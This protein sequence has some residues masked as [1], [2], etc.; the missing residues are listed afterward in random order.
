M[1]RR[2]FLQGAAAGAAT[3][4]LG[5]WKLQPRDAAA[6]TASQAAAPPEYSGWGDV[7]RARWSWDRVGRST[8]FVNCWPQA[9]CTWNVYLKDGIAWREE[10]A[11]DY[12]QTRPDVP[13]FNPRGCQKGACYSERMYDPSRLQHPLK[14]AG[15]RGSGRW[16]RI[17]WEQ[18]LEEIADSL[19]ET[20]T[21]EAS[22]RVVF[23]LGPLYTLGV[24]SAAQQGLA[25][26]LDSVSLDPNTEIGDGMRGLGETFGKICFDRSGDDFFFSDL[27]LIWGGNPVATQIPNVHFL[28][29]ARYKGA[30]VVFIGPDYSPSAIHADLW[31]PVKPGC[32]A[33]LALGIAQVLVSKNL[34]DRDFVCEQTDLP[35]LVREDT[36]LYLRGSDLEEGGSDEQLYLHDPE[37]GVVA[38]PR[39]SLD[40]G[41]LRPSLD[42]RF[43]VTLAD[44]T[45]TTV[46]AVFA[47]LREQLA[48][49]TPEKASKLCGT[50]P[51]LIRDLARRLARAR[52]ASSLCTTLFAKY[53][54]GNLVMRAQALVFSLTG[55][56][57]KKGSGLAGVSFLVQDGL[58]RFAL[59]GLPLGRQV[60]LIAGVVADTAR[61]WLQGYTDE[62]RVFERYR[63]LYE[64][65]EL[66]SGAL[67]WYVHGG[68]VQASDRLQDWD[69]YLGRPVREV[70]EESL[71]KGWQHVWPKPGNDPRV[72][73]AV[74]S[75][76]LRRVRSYPRLLENLWPKLRTIVTLDWRM[77]STALHSDYVL[78]ITGWYERAEI[79]W[80]TALTPFVHAGAK[81]AEPHQESK[82]D[83]EVFSLLAK[84]IQQ[85]ARARGVTTFLDR[86]GEERRLDDVYENF[87][88]GGE[89]GPGDEEKVAEALLENASNLEGVTWKQLKERGWARFTSLGNSPVAIGSATEVAPD[90]TI[91]HFTQHV[92]EK[93]PWPT[94][95]RRIQFFLD[96]ELYLEMGEELPRHKDP[97]TAGGDY[98]LVLS[99]GHTRWSIHASWRDDALMLQQ[100]RG[101]PVIYVGALDAEARGIRD[102]EMVR[103]FNDLGEFQV[104]AKVSPGIRPGMLVIYHA[105]ENYQFQGGVGYQSLIPSPLNPVELSGGQHHLRPMAPCMQ[106]SHTDRDTRVEVA[107]L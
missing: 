54:H 1:R 74:G 89:F 99:G 32:D 65:G 68:V 103:V 44:G 17:G 82:S 37:R 38:A 98:P 64:S 107:R 75:N 49:Y 66:M 5:L 27:I 100:Q 95:S 45:P 57:G 30:Q 85:Q 7:Y 84:S 88:R 14:R 62:M 16:Q 15:E 39:R 71:S 81:V 56:F 46:R 41:E 102:G 79:K 25:L 53:Y 83:W 61:L 26:L 90:D 11:G 23:D 2:E 73:F 63:R 67:F 10:Q 92:F 105:W 36:G 28:N 33:A 8:H 40:L 47:R 43:Q 60:K 78:P 106:P 19:I 77:S 52:A 29:E 4:A 59:S 51:S 58:E 69:P 12:P 42:G 70:L 18:A 22:D 72:L 93:K 86:H 13:D 94:R 104:R 24:L 97:P 3:V 76:P 80:V 6:Q 55:Q 101:E 34:F 96:Q 9:H 50:R 20:I 87:S 21:E 31:V 35:L 48:D 91:T